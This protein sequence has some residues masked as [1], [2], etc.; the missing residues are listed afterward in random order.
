MGRC[1]TYGISVLMN[2]KSFLLKGISLL[3]NELFPYEKEGMLLLSGLVDILRMDSILSD[4]GFLSCCTAT[5]NAKYVY[6]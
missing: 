1:P 2:C 4:A 6:N 5:K 3:M